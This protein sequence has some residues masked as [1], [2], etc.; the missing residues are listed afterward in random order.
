HEAVVRYAAERDDDLAAALRDFLKGK[1]HR[2]RQVARHRPL[3]ELLREIYDDTGYLAF[4]RGLHNGQQRVANLL[5]LHERASQFGSFSRQGLYRFLKFLDSLEAETDF[6]QPSV[7]SEAADVVR[8]MSVHHSKGLEFP[9]VF[10]PEMG[11]RINLQDCQGAILIDKHAGLGMSA[12]DEAR[13]VR[14]P[15]LASTLVRQS[16]RKQS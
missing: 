8:V 14:Y 7:L 9:V 10:L 3:A 16:L 1:L 12:V 15:S 4:C 2:W 11:K 5:E 13:R 6:G